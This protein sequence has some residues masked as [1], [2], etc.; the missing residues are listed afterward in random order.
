MATVSITKPT[1]N[2]SS[3]TWGTTLNQAL[4]DIVTGV[5]ARVDPATVTAKGDILAASASG[6]LARQAVGTNGQILTAD[7]TATNGV[8]WAPPAY[9]TGRSAVTLDASGIGTITHN[10]GA[11]PNVFIVQPELGSVALFYAPY[12]LA[13]WTTTTAT[14]RCWTAAGAAANGTAFSRVYWFVA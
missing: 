12:N 7:S 8:K 1:V 11:V 2:G 3:G 6:V 5:N 4:D 10:L 9:L 13:G 14:F